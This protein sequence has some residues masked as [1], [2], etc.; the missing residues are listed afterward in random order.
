MIGTQRRHRPAR[1]GPRPAFAVLALMLALADPVDAAAQARMRFDVANRTGQIIEELYATPAGVQGWGRDL[2]GRETLPH[3]QTVSIQTRP[4]GGCLY[5]VRAVLQNGYGLEARHDV[6]R[7]PVVVIARD[8]ANRGAEEAEARRITAAVQQLL[9]QLG[10]DPGPA[11]GV[12]GTQTQAAIL[13]FQR[14]SGLPLT[15]RIDEVLARRL[16]AAVESQGRSRP[17]EPRPSAPPRRGEG[18]GSS[19]TG[20]LVSGAGHVLTNAHVVQACRGITL[21]GSQ[22]RRI[23]ARLLRADRQRDLALLQGVRL[24]G[25]P[26]PFH[27]G[28]TPIRPGDEIVT[29]GFP[30]SG[31][32]SSSPTLTTGSISSLAG[33]RD[34]ADQLQFSAPVQQG[35]SGGPLLDRSGAVVGVIVGKLNALALAGVTGDLPQNVNFAIQ[36]RVAVAFL[37]EAGVTPLDSSGWRVMSP[38][39]IGELVNP[40]VFQVECAQ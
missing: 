20:F 4:G 38:A 36:G 34:N 6:C 18:G 21:R 2:L 22:N 11:D 10:Y 37:R 19:G 29:Y 26:L 9:A 5:D 3:G 23:E 14:D 33:L 1:P 28:G 15:G 8:S 31:L 39:D 17:P 27:I 30:L 7:N 35:N 13:N 32:L 25:M 16:V 12:I 40:S 24:T